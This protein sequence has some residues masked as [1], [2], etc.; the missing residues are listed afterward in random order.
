M[1]EP[2]AP[3]DPEAR[4]GWEERGEGLSAHAQ[5]KQPRMHP[6]RSPS[7]C[8]VSC[9]LASKRGC[10]PPGGP[11]SVLAESSLGKNQATSHSP[12]PV[13]RCVVSHLV[14]PLPGELSGR[15]ATAT[16]MGREGSGTSRSA[17]GSS[18][19]SL[20]LPHSSSSSNR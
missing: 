8:A 13:F 17:G 10:S 18:L 6:S 1:W 19:C 9:V 16:R 5:H 11:G 7:E 3:G 12:V 2:R 4:R 15:G 14:L 20:L